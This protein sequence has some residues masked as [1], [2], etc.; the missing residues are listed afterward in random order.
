MEE[1]K[2]RL[3][4]VTKWN[5]YHVWPPIGGLRHLIFHEH[6]NGFAKCVKRV[7]RTVLVDEQA[8]LDWASNNHPDSKGAQ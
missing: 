5:D 3:I 6:E 1:R 8:F 2:T 4:P 7:G